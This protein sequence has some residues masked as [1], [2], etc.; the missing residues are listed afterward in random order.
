MKGILFTPPNI[1]LIRDGKKT[2]TRRL[3][4]HYKQGPHS[5]EFEASRYCPGETVYVKEAIRPYDI[6]NPWSDPRRVYTL[7]GAWAPSGI[8]LPK[9]P[10]PMFMKA[11]Y[12]RTFLKI[13]DVRPERLQE[14]TGS[15]AEAEGITRDGLA[16]AQDFDINDDL[17]EHGLDP[18][19]WKYWQLWDAINKK[20]GTRW[21]DNPFV[22]VYTFELLHS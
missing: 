13:I 5:I 2:Q 19:R 4:K 1:K 20:P 17:T 18:L 14:I 9:T 16:W 3:I 22:W 7:D 21:A 6:C 12:A 11:E 8:V 15:D 10:S